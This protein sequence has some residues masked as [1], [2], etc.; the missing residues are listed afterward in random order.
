MRSSLV[1]SVLPRAAAAL[2]AACLASSARP[3]IARQDASLEEL[4]REIEIL[5]SALAALEQ[6]LAGLQEAARPG[7]AAAGPAPAPSPPGTPLPPERGDTAS[8]SASALLPPSGAG[9]PPGA[10]PGSSLFNPDIG[11][12]FQA[13]GNASL[14]HDRDQDWFTLSEAEIGLQSVVDPY[15][16]VDLFLSFNAEG[17]AEVEEG[18]VTTTALPGGLRL[19]GGRFR[20]SFGRWNRL[21]DHQFFTVDSP[22]VL[23][24]LFGEE[25]LAGDGLS[26]DWLI[27]TIGSLYLE[28]ITEVASA[29]SEAVFGAQGREPLVLQRLGSVFTLTSQATLGAGLSAAAGRSGPS[30]ALID[31]LEEAGLTGVLE[32]EDDLPARAAGVDVS[33]KWKPARTGLYRSATLQG[34]LME[35]RGRAQRLE[36]GRLRKRTERVTGGYALGEYQFARRWRAGLRYDAAEFAGAPEA[37]QSALSAVLRMAPSEFQEIRFQV[38]RSRRNPEGAALFD[39]IDD[40][41]ELFIEWI[42]AIGAHAAHAY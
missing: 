14:R 34:E 36:D 5:K 40:D 17:E 11:A 31:A 4:R 16:R 6:R 22:D 21:H 29:R 18:T 10:R 2:L 39:G 19:K 26:L 30:Q 13:I 25:G 38:K 28:S 24:A 37:R 42:P 15:A 35:A 9:G 27:P 33:F 12:V 23:G 32:P 20:S 3:A 1:R 8:E 7:T 41:T